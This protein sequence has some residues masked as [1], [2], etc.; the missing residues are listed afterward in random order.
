MVFWRIFFVIFLCSVYGCGNSNDSRNSGVEKNISENI[1]DLSGVKETDKEKGVLVNQEE[2]LVANENGFKPFN[3]Y[4]DKGTRDNHYVPS[5]FMPTGNC[6]SFD[7]RWTE[8]CHAGSTCIKIEYDIQCSREDQKWAGIY[9]LNPSNNWGEKKGGYDLTGANKLTF[10]A[11]GAEG[12]EQINEFTIGGITG[13]YPDSDL[14][15]IGPILLSS[16]WR[17]YT[18]D[19]RGKNLSHISAGFAWSTS[20]EVNYDSCTFYLD[21]IRFE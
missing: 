8:K 16:E 11:K 7:D 4:L 5:G 12:G 9:W 10:W 1:G 20:E 17:K 2:T 6:L 19:L 13:D 3:V 15:V 14:A 21:N 18:I